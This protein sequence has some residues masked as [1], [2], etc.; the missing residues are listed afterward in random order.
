MRLTQLLFFVIWQFQMQNS[1]FGQSSIGCFVRGECMESLTIG[2]TSTPQGDL[3]CLEYCTT[4]DGSSYFS[5]DPQNS[6]SI[7]DHFF[8]EGILS[9]V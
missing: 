9:N 7:I 6:V 1:V 3:Q 2:G 5:Y 8:C 4:V